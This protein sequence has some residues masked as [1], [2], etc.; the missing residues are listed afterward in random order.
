LRGDESPM[1]P[2]LLR[3]PNHEPHLTPVRHAP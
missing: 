2:S 1:L 3:I